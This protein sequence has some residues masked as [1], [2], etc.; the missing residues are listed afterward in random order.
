NG[1]GGGPR[2]SVLPPPELVDLGGGGGG[3]GT[4]QSQSRPSALRAHVPPG[5]AQPLSEQLVVIAPPPWTL[6]RP[7]PAA[8]GHRSATYDITVRIHTRPLYNMLNLL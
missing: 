5:L 1:D 7:S 6:Q 8:R 4:V 3:G 2:G